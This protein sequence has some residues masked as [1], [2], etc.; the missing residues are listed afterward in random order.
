M[1]LGNKDYK[2]RTISTTCTKYQ[3]KFVS[4]WAINSFILFDS[5]SRHELLRLYER[6]MTWR[7]LSTCTLL[8][9]STTFC[10]YSRLGVGQVQVKV[11]DVLF[12]TAY[13]FYQQFDQYWLM[14]VTLKESRLLFSLIMM[15]DQANY[16]INVYVYFHTI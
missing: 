11:Q 2:N 12:L 1:K 6:M 10:T 8:L 7:H 9:L 15:N 14:R 3:L 16:T 13:L 5:V 4:F